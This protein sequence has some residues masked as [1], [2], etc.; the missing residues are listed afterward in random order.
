MIKMNLSLNLTRM[1]SRDLVSPLFPNGWTWLSEFRYTANLTKW[2]KRL[3]DVLAIETRK[4]KVI[5]KALKIYSLLKQHRIVKTN[6]YPLASAP[7]LCSTT[8]YEWAKQRH[9]TYIKCLFRFL[10]HQFE[11]RNKDNVS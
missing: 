7:R 1:I 3:I 11:F 6:W 10:D 9:M 4:L 2:Y 8:D 5:M